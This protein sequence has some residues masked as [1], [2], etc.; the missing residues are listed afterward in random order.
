[1]AG[2]YQCRDQDIVLYSMDFFLMELNFILSF[3]PTEVLSLLLL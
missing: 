1:M 2:V 3:F